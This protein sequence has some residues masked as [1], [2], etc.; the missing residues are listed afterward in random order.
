MDSGTFTRE[1]AEQAS[2]DAR[3][4][5]GRVR[6][7]V[8]G[9]DADWLG[10]EPVD[11]TELDSGEMIKLILQTDAARRQLDGYLAGLLARFGDLEGQDAVEELC[12]QF[13]L[14]RHRARQQAKTAEAL[15]AL[16]DTLEASK[17]GWISIDHARVMGESHQRAPMSPEQEIEL[18]ALAI[19]EDLDQF[20][21]T[22]AR[23]ED[24][25]QSAD[26]LTRSEQ[27]RLRRKG[28]VFDGDSDMVVLHAEIDRIAGE[29]V[30]T[31]LFA[32]TD[33]MFREDA[34]TGSDRTHEQRTADALVALITQRPEGNG[35][36]TTRAG[37]PD[38]ESAP[39]TGGEALNAD[40]AT[41]TGLG[42]ELT[43]QATTLIVT[44][45][46]DILT[47]QL[48]NA[49]LI[50]GTPIDLD[51]LR[52]I[53]CDAGIIPAIFAADGQPL[54]LGR[55]QRAA[56]A[57][58]K[59]ALYARD[60]HCIGCGLRPTACDVHHIQWWDNNGATDIDNLVL[61][62]PKCHD[63]VHKHGYTVTHSTDGPHRLRPPPDGPTRRMLDHHEQPIGSP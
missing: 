52:R 6:T 46:Y 23:L 36:G 49:S 10:V 22:A 8:G 13:G 2:A 61:L 25:R 31:S 50:D 27:Q 42:C 7:Y 45:A 9:C 14:G 56:T 57:A 54:Y 3:A 59:L 51:E 35:T 18:V 40:H 24:Q 58:Q 60:K 1:N 55:K 43:P 41:A 4:G 30:K 47:D 28:K 20:K 12:R 21:K 32:L 33:R 5:R 38:H 53:A 17:Q 19:K 11:F 15:N 16:P 29:R 37:R 62:C 63:K 26:G 34:K 44:V 48:Q 39:D